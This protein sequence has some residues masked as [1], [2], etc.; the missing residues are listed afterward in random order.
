VSKHL[1]VNGVTKPLVDWASDVGMYH[2]TLLRRMK[3]G[4]PAEKIVGQPSRKTS[5]RPAMTA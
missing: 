5:H 1:T 3:A 2:S 4:W